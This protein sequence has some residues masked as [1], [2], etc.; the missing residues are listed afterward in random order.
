M[1]SQLVSRIL[2]IERDPARARQY[3]QTL[4]NRHERGQKISFDLV[5]TEAEG[6]AVLAQ[7]PK[8]DLII[9]CSQTLDFSQAREK[10]RL[11][12]PLKA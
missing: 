7:D 11:K 1:T 2:I 3:K 12:A 6:A 8:P 10:L 9:L 4:I 5:A